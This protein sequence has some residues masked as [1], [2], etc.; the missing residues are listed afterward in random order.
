[1]SA[2]P[3]LPTESLVV[4]DGQT[5]LADAPALARRL[6]DAEIRVWTLAIG[7]GPA[8]DILTRIATETGGGV[9]IEHDAGRWPGQLAALAQRA[10]AG[11]LMQTPVRPQRLTDL[12]VPAEA[13]EQWNRTWL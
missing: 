2:P 6:R 5:D 10:S 11:G 8:I 4:T 13:V 3:D 12:V 1:A 9:L 7:H